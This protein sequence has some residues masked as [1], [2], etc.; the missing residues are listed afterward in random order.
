MV[1]LIWVSAASPD[2]SPVLFSILLSSSFPPS[3]P[4]SPPFLSLYLVISLHFP[5]FPS[6]SCHSADESTDVFGEGVLKAPGKLVKGAE[7]EKSPSD[8]RSYRALTLPNGLRVLLASDPNTNKAAAALDVHVGHFSDPDN[9]PGMAHF[10]EHMLFLGTEKYPTEGALEKFLSVHGGSSNAYTD[11]EDTNYFFDVNED[12]LEGALDI[13]SQFFVSPLFTASGVERELNAIESEHSKN[14]QTDS[15]RINQ[16]GK[17]RGNQAHPYAKFGT[18]NKYTLKEN[19]AAEG[20]NLREKLLE[21]HDK[22]YSANQMTLAVCG[23]EDLDTLQKMVVSRF[24]SVP[25]TNRPTPEV[26]WQGKILPFDSE[27]Y[28]TIYNV[29]PVA[30]SKDIYLA[31]IMPFTSAEDRLAKTVGKPQFPVSSVIGY[32]GKGSLLSYLKDKK[33]WIT[34][35]GA[36]EFDNMR[37]FDIYGLAISLTKEGFKHREEIVETIFAYINKM[38]KEGIP[39]YIN[40]DLMEVCVF[41]VAPPPTCA[42]HGGDAFWVMKLWIDFVQVLCSG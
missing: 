13:F 32:E 25:N 27:A 8:K 1:F 33:G 20:I 37:D 22:Y 19:T 29:V 38:K 4:P 21:F 5:L 36:A 24:S 3:L 12:S 7:V 39:D 9:I 28:K 11:T 17:T 40:K 16:V 18:G 31:W 35:L 14:L 6:P 10:C 26:A 42:C 15:W 34:S 30:D 2:H 23:K 41:V